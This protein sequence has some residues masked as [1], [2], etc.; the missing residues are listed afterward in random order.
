[1][2][3]ESWIVA[4]LGTERVQDAVEEAGRRRLLS[5]L[6]TPSSSLQS[7]DQLRFVA[8]TLELDVLDA[9]AAD[10]LPRVR[11]SAGSAFQIARV[12]SHPESA[13]ERAESLVRL[14]C[15]GILGDRGA[16][17]RRVL[18]D[19][20][21][22]RLLLGSTWGDRVWTTVLHVWL[23]LFRK[24]GCDDLD[25]VQA[26]VAALRSDQNDQEPDFL[27]DAAERKDVTPAWEL[28]WCYHVAKAAEIV[29][30]HQTQGHAEGH[31]DV[32]EQ[33]DAQFDHAA[34][35]AVHGGLAR[36]EVLTRLLARTA[37]AV[38]E[39]SNST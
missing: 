22:E 8:N 10:D 39:S 6:D 17:V 38:V 33:L 21:L 2:S 28:I 20:D 27:R 34:T 12:L 3:G 24:N 14:G 18:R 7:D 1:M 9:I 13:V 25:A 31:H 11:R 5:A 30:M 23:L 36:Q 15:L 35:A 37:Q 4:S 32:G 29:G 26:Q 19:E 16:D